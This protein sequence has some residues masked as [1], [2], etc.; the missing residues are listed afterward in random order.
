MWRHFS[1]EATAEI[2]LLA[3]FTKVDGGIRGLVGSVEEVFDD[4]LMDIVW[5]LETTKIKWIQK[6]AFQASL[7]SSAESDD[8]GVSPP[9][10]KK[11]RF[12]EVS[13]NMQASNGCH[14]GESASTSNDLQNGTCSFE[15]N[16]EINGDVHKTISTKIRS[17]T[18]QD[19][20]RLIGQHL[21]GLGLKCVYFSCLHNYYNFKMHHMTFYLSG[22]KEILFWS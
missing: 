10:F 16:V 9:P 2:S 22:F 13:T 6:V 19:I 15:E 4:T 20:I 14:N 1:R 17:Q 3:V 7:A 12:S 11:Q 5:V 8:G 18:D 21:R